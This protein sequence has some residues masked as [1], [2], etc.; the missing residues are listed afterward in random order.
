MGQ[1]CEANSILFLKFRILLFSN[2]LGL[3]NVKIV[4]PVR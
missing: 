3:L 4:N 1:S 2:L